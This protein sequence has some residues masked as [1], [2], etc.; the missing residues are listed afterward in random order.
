MCTLQMQAN[1]AQMRE[2][3]R[4]LYINSPSFLQGLGGAFGAFGCTW[5]LQHTQILANTLLRA[6]ASHANTRKYVA[7][8]LL[9]LKI[10]G[11][12]CPKA[13]MRSKSQFVIT[14]PD[15]QSLLHSTLFTSRC[16]TSLCALYLHRFALVYIY[17]YI[18]LCTHI[19]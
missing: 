13:T 1:M 5:L 12:A 16:C 11:Q 3:Q 14:G 2:G 8:C 9:A 10:T 7:S 6:Y 18:C 19:F 15:H 4:H 17:I